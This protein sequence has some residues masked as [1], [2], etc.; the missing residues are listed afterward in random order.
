LNT[1]KEQLEAKLALPD[2][3]GNAEEF[4]KTEASY[5]QLLSKLDVATKEYEMIFEKIIT[6]D[7]DLLS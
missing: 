6:L 2:A 3:Y 1:Q 5:K 4:K 7:E